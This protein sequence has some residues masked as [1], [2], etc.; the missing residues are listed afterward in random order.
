MA[1]A[2]SLHE[3]FIE[4]LRDTYDAEKQLIKAL[5]KLAKAAASTD[6][7]TGALKTS[8]SGILRSPA[9]STAGMFLMLKRN[10]VPGPRISTLSVFSISLFNAFIPGSSFR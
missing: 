6:L 5:P 4:E 9:H 1:Q 8:P 7:R 3:A 10:S 2:G